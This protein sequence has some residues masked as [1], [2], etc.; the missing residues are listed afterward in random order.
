MENINNCSINRGEK[1][2]ILRSDFLFCAGTSYQASFCIRVKASLARIATTGGVRVR[3][4]RRLIRF[5]CCVGGRVLRAHG[6]LISVGHTGD[7]LVNLVP[8]FLRIFFSKKN[9]AKVSF[10]KTLTLSGGAARRAAVLISKMKQRQIKD[11]AI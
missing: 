2:S 8:K 10:I 5:N 4:L 1:S 3:L 7:I 11:K 6:R 9:L